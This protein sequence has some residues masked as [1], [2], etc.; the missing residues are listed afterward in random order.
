MLATRRDLHAA[1]PRLQ[2]HEHARTPGLHEW[3]A[4]LPPIALLT[5]LA[6]RTIERT[7]TTR[8]LWIGR[9]LRP[10]PHALLRRRAHER[11]TRL[12][13]HSTFVDTD[14]VSA[15]VWA[16]ELALRCDA[17]G[18][19]IADG[20]GLRMPASRRLQLCAASAGTPCL[21]TRPEHEQPELSAA[22]TRWLVTPRASEAR[23]QAWTLEL[24]RCKGLQPAVGDARR[25]V[26]HRDHAR[27]SISEWTP[28]D[29]GAAPNVVHRPGAPARARI[30]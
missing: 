5:D 22:R 13:D 20:A 26:A 1:E 18:M 12:L 4:Q 14:D 6:W 27:G 11:D 24:L 9:A 23:D 30:A 3:F 29:V 7:P 10:Y 25:W 15:R 19:V 8:I 16:A 2:P 21:L 17:V 28:S